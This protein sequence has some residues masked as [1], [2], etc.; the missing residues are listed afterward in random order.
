MA[1]WEAGKLVM[2]SFKCDFKA[3]NSRQTSELYD[4]N[5]QIA[6]NTETKILKMSDHPPLVGGKLFISPDIIST[7]SKP[8]NET[9]FQQ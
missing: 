2:D 7:E 5:T 4:T 3:G 8:D 9:Y 1:R 6:D